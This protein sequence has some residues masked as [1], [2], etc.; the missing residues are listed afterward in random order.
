MSA[1]TLFLTILTLALAFGSTIGQHAYDAGASDPEIKI[2]NAAPYSGRVSLWD[3]RE[4]GSRVLQ[5]GERSSG[6]QWTQDQ[7][8]Q[9]R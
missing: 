3:G 1:K 7:L 8:H 5:D 9:L 6:H 2:G 4:G